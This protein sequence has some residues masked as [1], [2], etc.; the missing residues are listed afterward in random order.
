[1]FVS[2]LPFLEQSNVYTS[3]GNPLN[4][5]TAGTNIGHRFVWKNVSCPSD[6]TWGTGLGEG[7]WAS[8]S[9]LANFQVFGNPNGGNNASAN[10]A[11][12]PNLK[13]SFTDGTSNTLL[14]AEQY[15][16]RPGGHWLLWAH[17]GWNDSWAPIFAYGSADGNTNYNSGMDWGSGVVGLNSKFKSMSTSAF[18]GS[19][20]GTDINTPIALHTSGMNVSLADGSVRTLSNNISPT[21][22]WYACTPSGGEVLGSDW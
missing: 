2:L 10:C 14:F 21:T 13:S 1:V 18:A 8:G 4:L 5:Q 17:G 12:F 20:T 19:G 15:A 6:P 16:Q 22:W 9:Y 11:G 7:D 3:F